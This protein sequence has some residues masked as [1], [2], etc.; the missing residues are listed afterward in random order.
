MPI[1]WEYAKTAV[2][3]AN[4]LATSIR[5]RSSQPVNLDYTMND[6][7]LI[8]DAHVHV[9]HTANP[10]ELLFAAAANFSHVA[11]RAVK[12][13]WQ[14]VLMLAEME[15]TN[16]FESLL[17]AEGRA[18][19][20]GWEVSVPSK[21][22]ISLY[23]GR[24]DMSM[25]VVAGRQ[26]VTAEG[27]EVLALGTRDTIANG[28]S[29]AETLRRVQESKAI[30]VLPWG[31][32]KWLGRRGKLVMEVIGD[33]N[34]AVGHVFA[35]DNSGR[36]VFWPA[37]RVFDAAVSRGHPVLPGTDPLPLPGEE[38]RVGRF[39]FWLTGVL[40]REAPATSLCATLLTAKAGEV[41]PYGARE[42]SWR[43]VYNQIALRLSKLPRHG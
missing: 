37:P 40:D 21:E 16:W 22:S 19:L 6:S 2:Q 30:A 8:V 9:H 14:G 11:R 31:A 4:G 25:L 41:H 32:G 10:S 27:L 24:G 12:S 5:P 29:L 35:G 15:G 1:R 28:M 39:G 7:T 36:P 20:D 38:G 17:A 26:I 23:V 43:F 33:D 34:P 42:S 18:G 13:S 3:A